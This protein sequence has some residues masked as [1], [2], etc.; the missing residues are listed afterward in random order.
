MI[1]T[2]EVTI[3]I[4]KGDQIRSW[5]I[6]HPLFICISSFVLLKIIILTLYMSVFYYLGDPVGDN[7]YPRFHTGIDFFDLLGT[8]WDSNIYIPIAENGY[9]PINSPDDYR[10]WVFPPLY[11]LF[12]RLLVLISPIEIPYT[13]SAVLTTNFF[14][15]TSVIA[16]FYMS[17]LYFNE[18]NSICASLLFAFFPPVLV[19]STVAYSE[20]IFFTFGIISWY[21]FEKNH[22]SLSSIALVLA[23]LT[24]YEGAILFFVYAGIFVGRNLYKEGFKST[25]G[26]LLAIP[27]F[28]ILLVINT[29]KIVL[30]TLKSYPR[31]SSWTNKLL[32]KLQG[33]YPVNI[34]VKN[35][36][37][38]II[39]FLN[40]NL[41]WILVWGVI[42]LIWLLHIDATAPLPLSK[43]RINHWGAR[44]EFPFAGFFDMI[45]LGDINWLIDKYTFVFLITIIGIFS[46]KKWPG[47]SALIISQILVYT[48]YIAAGW[49]IVRY[50][51]AI[52]QAHIV[53]MDELKVSPKMYSLVLTLFILYGFKVLWS[54]THWSLWLI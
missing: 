24:R 30:K 3:Q 22:F 54:F 40:P 36:F 50:V 45:S 12:I 11:P 35:K 31:G 38:E 5:I 43:I 14:S 29:I 20:P 23:T 6:N 41:S 16:F 19:F 33:K 32:E 2:D 4:K 52:F 13:V 46:M 1:N 25:I 10:A 47:L 7:G 28:P 51:G 48:S 9:I 34:N 37:F 39:D 53:I 26:M 17:R 15:I 8:R 27:L 21:F 18:I 49:S 42:P 44:F